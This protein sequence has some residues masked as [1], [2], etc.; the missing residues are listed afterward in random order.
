MQLTKLAKF[1]QSQ[2]LFK[3]SKIKLAPLKCMKYFHQ[4]SYFYKKYGNY[5]LLMI[6]EK[7]H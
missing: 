4:F 1:H 2:I 3:Y 7:N 6:S 5:H